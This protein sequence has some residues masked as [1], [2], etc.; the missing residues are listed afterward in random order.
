MILRPLIDRGTY[1]GGAWLLLGGAAVMPYMLVGL[2]VRVASAA[3]GQT[4]DPLSVV[5]PWLFLTMLPAVFVTG[6]VLPVREPLV[7]LARLLLS[8][9]IDAFRPTRTFSRR[10]R[11]AAWLTVHLGIGGV[12]SGLALALIPFAVVIAVQPFAASEVLSILVPMGW[13]PWWGLILGPLFLIGLGYLVWATAVALRHGAVVVLGPSASERLAA[14]QQRAADLAARNQMARELHDSVG[15]ALS[16]VTVQSAA[17]AR[18]L[19]TDPVFA[20]EAMSAVEGTA[21]R[22]LADLDQVLG[23][24]RGDSVADR[25]PSRGLDDLAELIEGCGLSVDAAVDAGTEAV[26]TVVSREAYR[27]VQECLTNALRHGDGGLVTVAIRVDSELS[28][29]VSNAIGPR[30]SRR[31]GRG[32]DGIRERVALLGGTASIGRQGGRWVVDVRLPIP[33]TP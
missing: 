12:V 5:D 30:T 2:V 10:C 4:G 7:F 31:S 17:A 15:H 16:V 25:T 33:S 14:S 3:P 9:P 21:R 29:M 27:I 24:L 11:D 22:A 32:V 6:L 8:A 18:V 23:I 19:D 20:R 1:R 26:G 13:R 28:I